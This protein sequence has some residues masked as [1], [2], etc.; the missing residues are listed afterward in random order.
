MID[1]QNTLLITSFMRY[2]TLEQKKHYL[3]RLCTDTICRCVLPPQPTLDI[4]C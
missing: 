3:T 2:G 1:I 4:Y